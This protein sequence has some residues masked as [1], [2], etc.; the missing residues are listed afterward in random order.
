MKGGEVVNIGEVLRT[1]RK[2]AG[3]TQDDMSAELN[4]SRST[5]SKLERNNRSI[6]TEDFIR[7]IQVAQGHLSN[8][9]AIEAGLTI[10]NG[11]D[12]N[13]LAEMLN[14]FVGLMIGGFWIG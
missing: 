10:V 6:Q 11:I 8:T 1:T 13:V 3:L 7:W 5:I 9:T 14:T 12:I 4:I 2:R